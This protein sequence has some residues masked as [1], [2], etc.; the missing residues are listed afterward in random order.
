MPL[1]IVFRRQ[2]QKDCRESEASLDPNGKFQASLSSLE[3]SCFDK[4]PSQTRG[5]EMV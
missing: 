1:I 5:R 4:K 3:R 2:S